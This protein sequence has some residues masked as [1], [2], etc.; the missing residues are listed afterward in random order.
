MKYN[1][2]EMGTTTLHVIK[3]DKFKTVNVV[4]M[5]R[6]NVRKEEMTIRRFLSKILVESTKQYPTLREFEIQLERQYGVSFNNDTY[7]VGYQSVLTYRMKA[8]D[9]Q[10]TE[11]GMFQKNLSLLNELLINPNIKDGKFDEREFGHV[12]SMIQSELDSI[13]DDLE[14]YCITRMVEEMEPNSPVSYRFAYQED[15]DKITPTSLYEYYKSV[16]EGDQIDIFVLGDFEI[17][18]VKEYFKD[19]FNERSMVLNSP[20]I[21][22]SQVLVEPKYKNEKEDMKQAKLSIGF[23]T[24]YLT[25]KERLY[26]IRLYTNILGGPSY[27]KLFL[28]V[29]EKNS[30]AY[31]IRSFFNTSQNIMIISSGINKENSEKALELIKV[32]LKNMVDGMITDEELESARQD[33]ISGIKAFEDKDTL[34]LNYYIISTLYHRGSFEESIEEYNRVTKEDLI[35]IAQKVKMDT[36]FLLYGDDEHEKNTNS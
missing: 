24:T 11:E 7:N 1:K 29:R 17:E 25:E 26:G 12:K 18:D 10:F 28:N 31:Y 34:V 20:V 33:A 23:K 6:R 30:L 9:E 8:L 15:L 13:K 35:R 4:V 5:F 27:S 32:E 22:H 3:T 2:V 36:V 14:S 16:I 19:W 21:E